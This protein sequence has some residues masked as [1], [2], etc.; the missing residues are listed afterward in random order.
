MD[1]RET[2]GVRNAFSY[3]DNIGSLEGSNPKANIKFLIQACD[4]KKSITVCLNI[5]T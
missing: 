4:Y 2:L 5:L 3:V 1:S